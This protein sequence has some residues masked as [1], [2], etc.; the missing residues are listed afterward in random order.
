MS[1]AL[2]RL[3]ACSGTWEGTNRLHDPHTSAPE[4]SAATGTLTRLLGGR[5][6]RFDY[7]W[8][9][10]GTDQEGSLLIGYQS[11]RAVVTVHWIDSWHMSEGVM[12]C[13]GVVGTDGAIDV[14]G[15]YAATTGPDWGW[16]IEL[17]PTGDE[18]LRLTMHNVDPDGNE[19]T[20]VECRLARSRPS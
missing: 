14:R 7:S 9:Y 19:Q 17:R 10:Q 1:P 16:R 4:D 18:T 3:S 12:P 5:F 11:D 15:T 2:S 20:A 13:K 6:L 8:A